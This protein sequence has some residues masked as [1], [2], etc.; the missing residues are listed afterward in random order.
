MVIN[1][2]Y[3]RK[4]EKD[5]IF[6]GKL[7]A[8]IKVV[9]LC[10][11]IGMGIVACGNSGQQGSL[12]IS[13]NGEKV[14]QEEYLQIMKER[15]FFVERYFADSFQADISE[16]GFWEGSF[17]GENPCQRLIDDTI[18][19]LLTQ[20]AMYSLAEERGYIEDGS[21]QGILERLEKEN[22][23]RAAKIERGEV[24]YGLTSFSLA[25]WMDYEEGILQE[26]FCN[27]L[28]NKEMQLT[29]EERNEFLGTEEWED[30]D[31]IPG[32]TVGFDQELRKAKYA[33]LIEQRAEE[34]ELLIDED[35]VYKFT[36]QNLTG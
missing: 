19:T 29:D 26:T 13:V 15:K 3:Q 23:L 2:I 30:Q 28:E 5:R 14:S 21:Y 16:K 18:S 24:V 9:L 6:S 17:G 4:K 8:F 27:D 7:L 11:V 33:N 22:T 12:S 20:R 31:G 35:A 34:A 32:I 36:L 25:Q 10:M 1:G